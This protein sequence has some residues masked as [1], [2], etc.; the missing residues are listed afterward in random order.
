[1]GNHFERILSKNQEEAAKRDKEKEIEKLKGLISTRLA[2]HTKDMNLFGTKDEKTTSKVRG[3]IKDIIDEIGVKHL[4]NSEKKG[5]IEEMLREITSLGK[6]HDLMMDPDV[7]EI[8]I[9][10]PDEVWIE[11][12]KK[13]YITENV[14]FKD[15]EEVM[16]LA[17]K[18][19]GYVKRR[20]DYS[21]PE[22]DARL[23]DGSR[24]HIIIPPLALKGV[25]ITIRKF[26]EER[27]TMDNLVEFDTVNE[28]LAGF[29]KAAVAARINIL[30][31]GGTG[32]GKT[33]TLNILSNSIPPGERLISIEDSA[34]LQLASDHV[35]RLEARLKN[36]EGSG[37]FTIQDLI[38]ASLRMR[39][40]RIIV[41]EV[42]DGSA[43]D[44]LQAM[45]TGHDGSMGT[46]HANDP[47]ECVER[48]STLVTYSGYKIPDK[49][50][51]T[52]IAGSVGLIVQIQRLPGGSRKITHV[53]EVTG[54]NK[55]T[56]EISINDLFLWYLDDYDKQGNPIGH[57]AYTGNQPSKK[58]T[59][60]FE[61]RKQNIFEHLRGDTP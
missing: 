57:F 17:R 33:T 6:I 5:L 56:E 29:L 38:K 48:L 15:D 12:N 40:D 13:V 3:H 60:Q 14:K 42:R 47:N 54:Y 24:V 45:N 35:V 2:V 1:M 36:A 30:V 20:L 39:P 8:M 55:A 26:S 41:G 37:E 27:L 10:A 7:K 21:N 22:V 4:S 46:V 52:Q 58:I 51:K 44:L 31:S 28:Q 9:N 49:T 34:E 23:P 53:S 25:T 59:N 50:I 16:N 18:I 43:L 61:H 19:V 32:S 11:K